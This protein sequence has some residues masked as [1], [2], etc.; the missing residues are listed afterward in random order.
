[1]SAISDNTSHTFINKNDNSLLGTSPSASSSSVTSVR[2]V[3]YYMTGSLIKDL[4]FRTV[5]SYF[6]FQDLYHCSSVCKQF[7]NGVQFVLKVNNG[8][9]F[10]FVGFFFSFCLSVAFCLLASHL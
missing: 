3:W 2:S 9:I 4:L 5:F 6:S 7:N 10:F 8:L 1:M